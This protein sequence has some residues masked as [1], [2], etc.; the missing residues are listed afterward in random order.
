MDIMPLVAMQEPM[1]HLP[2]H[3]MQVTDKSSL[4]PVTLLNV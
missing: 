1:F 4:Q 3:I 2:L